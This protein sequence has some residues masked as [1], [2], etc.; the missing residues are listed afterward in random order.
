MGRVNRITFYSGVFLLVVQ[1]FHT[2]IRAY[3]IPP[4]FMHTLPCGL[5]GRM[6]VLGNINTC[7]VSS[8]LRAR[9]HEM[10]Q[11]CKKGEITNQ[12]IAKG[13]GYLNVENSY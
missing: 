12:V 8:L 7:D 1:H 6:C 13:W 9:C 10:C 3:C 11:A 2:G 5:C 4:F